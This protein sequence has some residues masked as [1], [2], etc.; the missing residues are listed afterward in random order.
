MFLLL[1]VFHALCLIS[2]PSR[3]ELD[4]YAGADFF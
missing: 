3:P 1:H 2:L 4:V